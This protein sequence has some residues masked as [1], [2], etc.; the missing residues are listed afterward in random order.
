[1]FCSCAL[2]LINQI[3]CQAP[4]KALGVYTLRD[5]GAISF[6]PRRQHDIVWQLNV[7]PQ[8]ER[9]ALGV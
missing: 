5:P 1:M 6:T 7:G 2:Y 8:V 9:W 3:V 4:Y